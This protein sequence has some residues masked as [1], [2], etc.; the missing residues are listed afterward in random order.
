VPPTD[1]PPP[2]HRTTFLPYWVET[3]DVAVLGRNSRTGLQV[4]SASHGYPGEADYR[5]FHKRDGV[6]G[7]QYWRVSGPDVDLGDK[8]PWDPGRAVER[9]SGHADHFTGL[10]EQELRG[11][12]DGFGKHGVLVAAYDTE[13]FGHWWFEGVDWL[14]GVL[15]RLAKSESVETCTA[16]GFVAAHPPEDVLALPESSWGQAGNHFTW[17]NADTEWMWPI[18]HRAE[19]RMERLVELHPQPEAEL[20]PVLSQCARELLLLEAS[21]WPFL[22]TTGQARDYAVERFETHVSRFERLA[23]IGESGVVSEAAR[24]LAQELWELDRVF[25]EIDYRVF[26]RR[27]PSIE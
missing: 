21:D 18:I 25:P 5:E 13:L 12:H 26:A 20:L 9:V 3:P 8:E 1:Y 4:W 22:V 15:E 2:T 19:R 23:A 6:S 17:L 27:E 16:G 10:V 11:F 7:L 24:E 14:G